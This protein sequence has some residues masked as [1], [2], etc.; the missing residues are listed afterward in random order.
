M[1]KGRIERIEFVPFG[2]FPLPRLSR[3]KIDVTKRAQF[4]RGIDAR[5][6]G[7]SKAVGC[8]VFAITA[9]TGTLPWYIGKTTKL[10][11]ARETWATHRLVQY[12][13]ILRRRRLGTPLLFLV[14]KRTPQ[15]RFARPTKRGGSDIDL[16]EALMLESALLR[17]RKLQNPRSTRHLQSISLSGF[18]NAKPGRPSRSAQHLAHV[19]GRA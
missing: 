10:A 5:H 9:S 13:D 17:N 11:F 6:P 15:G 1:R 16:L 8:Y 14:A 4:W 2:P 18:I 19:L 12:Q 3:K 7:L